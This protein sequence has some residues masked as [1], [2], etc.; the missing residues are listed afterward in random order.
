MCAKNYDKMMY[1]SWDMV[2][3]GQ[4]DEKS[5]VVRLV[6]KSIF[7]TERNQILLFK[8]WYIGQINIKE[9]IEKTIA[10]LSIW[11]W[12]LGILDIDTQ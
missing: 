12:D 10:Q 1:G 8:L 11:K 5:D 4:M 7:Q 3:H 2:C 6:P 9:K